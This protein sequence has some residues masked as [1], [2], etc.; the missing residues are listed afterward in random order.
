MFSYLT[1]YNVILSSETRLTVSWVA[2]KAKAVCGVYRPNYGFILYNVIYFFLHNSR[3]CDRTHTQIYTI[4]KTTEIKKANVIIALYT[5]PWIEIDDFNRHRRHHTAPGPPIYYISI[6]WF[7]RLT[8]CLHIY[9]TIYYKTY[10]FSMF[11]CV[12]YIVP[13]C[14]YFVSLSI[15]N[16]YYIIYI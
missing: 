10:I 2:A 12:Y 7:F 8:R 16:K 4:T 14:I 5:I 9:P 11:A 15:Y 3:I 13:L 6:Y 1:H